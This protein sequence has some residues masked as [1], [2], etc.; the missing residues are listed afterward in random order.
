MGDTNEFKTCPII[1]AFVDKGEV[2]S[3]DGGY[4]IKPMSNYNLER[5]NAILTGFSKEVGFNSTSLAIWREIITYTLKNHAVNVK[6][7]T[8]KRYRIS[9]NNVLNTALSNDLAPATFLRNLL[10]DISLV[11][12]DEVVSKKNEKSERIFS[13]DIYKLRMAAKSHIERMAVQWLEVGI[14]TNIR[15]NELDGAEINYDGDSPTL[16]VLNTIKSDQSKKMIQSGLMATTRSINLSHLSLLDMLMLEKFIIESGRI[17]TAGGYEAFYEGIRQ[18]LFALSNKHLGYS[19]SLSVGRTQYA[20]NHRAMN[21]GCNR[22]LA[23]QMG[24]TDVMRASRS[25]G[26]KANGYAKIAIIPSEEVEKIEGLLGSDQ[27][28]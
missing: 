11:K 3:F 4:F 19:L 7:S 8:W 13:N 18:K 25:Y 12:V 2:T 6:S 28:E 26:K 5:L 24:H 22:E 23:D 14:L 21:P 27:Y 20:A 9:L 17:I 10:A 16:D 1:T 15:P